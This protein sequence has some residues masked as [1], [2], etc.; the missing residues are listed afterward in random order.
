M[1]VRQIG[2]KFWGQPIDCKM[3]VIVE[4]VVG[5]RVSARESHSRH[6]SSGNTCAPNREAG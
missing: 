1:L 2:Q 6:G 3:V 4:G 5:L